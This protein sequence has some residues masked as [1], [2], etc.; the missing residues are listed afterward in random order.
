MWGTGGAGPHGGAADDHDVKGTVLGVAK[1]TGISTSQE[2]TLAVG[3]MMLS[4]FFARP[5][6]RPSG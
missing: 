6:I 1:I 4:L 3:F 5:G 2:E